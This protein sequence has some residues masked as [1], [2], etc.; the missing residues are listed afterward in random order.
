MHSLWITGVPRAGTTFLASSLGKLTGY[1]V[2]PEAPM[3]TKFIKFF[4][5]NGT[6]TKRDFERI[7][8]ENFRFNH[9]RLD[10]HQ[11]AI[12]E[13]FHSSRQVRSIIHE[14]V[15]I[16]G[17]RDNKR[18]KGFIE[19]SPS[20]VFH[21]DS[22]RAVFPDAEVVFIVRDPKAVFNSVKTL[23]WGPNSARDAGYFWIQHVAHYLVFEKD[24]AKLVRYEDLVTNHRKTLT[25][26]MSDLNLTVDENGSRL[27]LPSYTQQQ[28][29]KVFEKADSSRVD[30]WRRDL[31]LY[32]Q[33]VIERMCRAFLELFHYPKDNELIEKT[34][35]RHYSQLIRATIK[36]L[37]LDRI[38]IKRRKESG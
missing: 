16:A 8:L 19:H 36:E 26:I 9:M 3:I 1:Y 25:E 34:P 32:E 33:V 11:L 22:I 12:P 37:I 17:I 7:V 30:A 38:S 24:I 15:S 6:A 4:V 5:I 35:S 28:H 2:L 10:K 14:L 18:Y 21:V 29:R 27:Q 20:N 31:S 13:T 23:D